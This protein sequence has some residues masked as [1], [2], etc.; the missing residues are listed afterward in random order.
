MFFLWMLERCE[1][2]FKTDVERGNCPSVGID[3]YDS[4]EF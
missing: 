1:P 3:I 4:R 2:S